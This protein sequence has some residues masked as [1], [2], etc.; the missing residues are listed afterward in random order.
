MPIRPTQLEPIASDKLI[1]LQLKAPRFVIPGGSVTAAHHVGFAAAN[2]AG[3]GP[4]KH[5][6][7]KELLHPVIPGEGEFATKWRDSLERKSLR[8]R[9]PQP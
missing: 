2:G 8:L 1:S 3:A 9:L 6:H 4:A 5:L 7:G